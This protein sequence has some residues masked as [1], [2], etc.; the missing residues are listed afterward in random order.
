M[1]VSSVVASVAAACSMAAAITARAAAFGRGGQQLGVAPRLLTPRRQRLELQEVAER[2]E[3]G[4]DAHRRVVAGRDLVDEGRDHHVEDAIDAIVVGLARGPVGSDEADRVQREGQIAVDMGAQAEQQ[5]AR[6][7]GLPAIG[8]VERDLPRRRRAAGCLPGV[9]RGEVEVG[10]DGVVVI[11]PRAVGEERRIGS[12]PPPPP[13]RSCGRRR[14]RRPRC[15]RSPGRRPAARAARRPGRRTGC[16]RRRTDPRC[17]CRR[18]YRPAAA[19]PTSRRTRDRTRGRRSAG[20][21]RVRRPVLPARSSALAGR[22]GRTVCNDPR[23][24]SLVCLL[25]N[26]T[27]HAFPAALI[28]RPAGADCCRRSMNRL[29]FGDRAAV[30][31]GDRDDVCTG[32]WLRCVGRCRRAGRRARRDGRG[33]GW[34]EAVGGLRAR[35]SAGD[36]RTGGG[37]R[38]GDRGGVRRAVGGDV[39]RRRHR[40]ERGGALRLRRPGVRRRRRCRRRARRRRLTRSARRRQASRRSGLRRRRRGG[41]PTPAAPALRRECGPPRRARSRGIRG[42]RPARSAGRGRRQRA[43]RRDLADGAGAVRVRQGVPGQRRRHRA[44]DAGAGSDRDRARLRTRSAPRH[45][46]AQRGA[47][48]PGARWAARRGGVPGGDRPS[49]PPAERFRVR[50]ARG[51][52]PAGT[53]RTGWPRP[54]STRSRPVSWWWPAMRGRHPRERRGGVR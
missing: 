27:L 44:R 33:A 23:A 29:A 39:E 18:P 41:G 8:G 50:A 37:S 34:A 15:G 43:G 6:R 17:R 47:E 5:V 53:T 13:S 54:S 16:V 1:S 24:L 26:A 14:A 49:R 12:A 42:R 2:A 38:A 51:P 46:H 3:P 10:E 40:L 31:R 52:A 28:V 45:R 9:P 11:Q 7:G 21:R 20:R 4:S 19:A 22:G 30:H 25:P 48:D 32:R 36:A 35:V